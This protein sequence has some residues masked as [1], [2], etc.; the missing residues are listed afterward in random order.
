MASF[1]FQAKKFMMKKNIT[2]DAR[3]IRSIKADVDAMKRQS[4]LEES[5]KQFFDNGYEATSL[6]SIAD[7]LGVTKQFIYSRFSSKS[8]ILVSIC[9]SGAEAAEKAVELSE[10]LE[11]NAAVRLA[12]I[13]QFFV[14]L[15]IEHRREVALYFRESKSLPAEE[16]R[17]IDASKLRFHRMLCAVL[18][19][20]KAAGL[21]EFDDTS[22]AASALGGMISWPFFW[23]Q[24]EGR[25]DPALVARQLAALALKTVGVSDPSIHDDNT[26]D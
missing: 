23:F 24:P 21:F 5:V 26:T 13:V 4:V 1:I 15:Q 11:G 7:A 25:W 22:I 10:V 14:Q 18:N 20:G 17:A 6:E 9:R 3:K 8:E 19:E 2:D 12:R 16:A